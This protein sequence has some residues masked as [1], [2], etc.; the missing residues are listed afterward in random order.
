M[1]LLE[2]VRGQVGK[3]LVRTDGVVVLAPRLGKDER[4]LPDRRRLQFDPS[5]KF[6]HI[7]SGQS[8]PQTG[9]AWEI[10]KP[11]PAFACSAKGTQ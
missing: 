5:A 1:L 10:V 11:M 7:S 4:E 8:N 3:A 2:L 9:H 6:V